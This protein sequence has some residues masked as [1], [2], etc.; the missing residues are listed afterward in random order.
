MAF[1]QLG[2]N[3]ATQYAKELANA[4]PYLSYFGDIYGGEMGE[5]Y[6]PV[7]GKTVAIPSMVVSGAR[8]V[9]RDKIT[10]EFNRNFNNEWQNVIMT[11]DREWDTIVDP[12]DIV[13]TNDV[14]TIANVTRTFNETQK[15][16]EMDAYMSQ[17]LAK[18]AVKDNE[19][20]TADNILNAWDGYLAQL[21]NARIA[22]DRV[23]AYLTPESY[24]L[25]KQAAGISRF[26]DISGGG[27]RS[28]D[29]NIGGLDGVKIIETPSDLMMTAYDFTNGWAATI[30]AKQINMLFVDPMAVAAPVVY[31]TSMMS[32]PSAQSKGK[33]IY[34]ERYYYDVFVLANRKKGIIANVEA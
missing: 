17:Q 9:N 28:V 23:R 12:M 20:L 2:V 3:Y 8:A 33:Y 16:P 6:K 25:L 29:R 22:R 32:P 13:E 24:K 4:Y 11:M 14:A 21:K 26:V 34:Y 5:R 30:S 1:E 15:I 10:G 7:S 19:V 27:E 18:E 31:E